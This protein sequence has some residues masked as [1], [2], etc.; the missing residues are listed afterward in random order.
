MKCIHCKLETNNPKYCSRSCA[1]TV[2]NKKRRILKYCAVC[3]IQIGRRS[4]YCV[5]HA[6][7]IAKLNARS[8]DGIKLS[9][10]RSAYQGPLAFHRLL[11]RL[12]RKAYTGKLACAVCG[13][14][15]HVDVCHIKD[16]ASFDPSAL[17]S[18][19]NDPK[20]LTALCPTHHW[21]FDNGLLDAPS[22]N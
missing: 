19:V 21:E 7:K 8:F 10:I 16:V 3:K 1:V 17:L 11:R 9:D 15:K 13:Y 2:N 5:K 18:D 12:S 22:W 14:N 6:N 20:N 4:T